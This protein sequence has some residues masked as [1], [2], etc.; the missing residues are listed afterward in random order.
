[1]RFRRD[2]L[3]AY[4]DR[5]AVCALREPQLVQAAHIVPFSDPQ[6]VAAV[7]NGIALCAIHHLAYD[8]NLLGI[9]PGGVVHI[10]AR[11]LVVK[12]GPMLQQG[13]VDFDGKPIRKPRRTQDQPDPVRLAARYEEFQAAA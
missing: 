2:V 9:G 3:R 4:S 12:D 5:C 11:L 1:M 7:V 8:R 10:G 13:L 6:G